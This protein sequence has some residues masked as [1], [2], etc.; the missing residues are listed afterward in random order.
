MTTM[1]VLVGEQTVPNFLP[2]RHYHPSDVVFVYTTTTKQQYEHL[3]D[4]LQK[5]VKVHKIETEPYNIS[6]IIEPLKEGLAEIALSA[7][8]TLLFNLTGGTKT[9][10]IAAYQVAQQRNA[11]VIYVQS[12]GM[13]SVVDLYEWKDAGLHHKSREPLPEYLN[14]HEVLD[15]SLGQGKDAGG[16]YL[17]KEQVPNPRGGSGH[18]FELAIAQALRDYKKY[19]VMCGVQGRNN[20]VDVDV[21]IRYRN[22]IGIIEAKIGSGSRSLEGVKQLSTA[23]LYLRGTY[24][25]QFLVINGKSS[26]DQTAMCEALRINIISLP[27]YQENMNTLT[28]EDSDTLLTEINKV[29]KVQ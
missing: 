4:V 5:E 21:M 16:K 7:S 6:H 8:Q 1:I 2:V 18:I 15:L 20:Q 29:M 17:W 25:Q 3:K 10:V 23:K 26:D 27:H 11:P 12:E 19:E 9:M 28:Q 22:Q 13:Q 24:N 14:L